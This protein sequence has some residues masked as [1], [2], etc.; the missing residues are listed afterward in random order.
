MSGTERLAADVASVDVYVFCY[1]HLNRDVSADHVHGVL[2]GHAHDGVR[3]RD[4]CCW[5]VDVGQSDLIVCDDWA[6]TLVDGEYAQLSWYWPVNGKYE[7]LRQ[8]VDGLA[9]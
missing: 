5:Y 7:R 3:T 9:L 2:T 1:R 8:A 6:G 4:V